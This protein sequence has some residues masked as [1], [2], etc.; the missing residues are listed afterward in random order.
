M[1]SGWGALILVVSRMMMQVPFSIH[2][3]PGCH[4]E[5]Q[6]HRVLVEDSQMY[7]QRVLPM[8]FE[9]APFKITR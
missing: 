4:P 5:K 7:N 9:N 2:G 3:A 1:P 8:C 6:T